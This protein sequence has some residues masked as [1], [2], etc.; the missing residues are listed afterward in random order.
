MDPSIYIAAYKV[1]M[2]VILEAMKHIP[3]YDQRKRDKFFNLQIDITNEQRRP[4]GKGPHCRD[5]AK[6]I[7]LVEKAN[8]MMLIFK[9]EIKRN[10]I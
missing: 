1:S 9:N 4:Y 2:E 3:N 7:E 6:I 5:E 8:A 10:E